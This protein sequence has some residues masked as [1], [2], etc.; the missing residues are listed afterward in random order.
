MW[1]TTGFNILSI[2]FRPIECLQFPRLGFTLIYLI[3]RQCVVF[4][5]LI[6][7]HQC[8]FY[9][10]EHDFRS[11]MLEMRFRRRVGGILLLFIIFHGGGL[12][13]V[14]R[15]V[16]WFSR[17]YWL[18]VYALFYDRS[19]DVSRLV[20]ACDWGWVA[21]ILGLA[22][23]VMSPFFRPLLQIIQE[24]S[25]GIYGRC[26]SLPATIQSFWIF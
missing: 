26:R 5:T 12:F 2:E 4:W 16:I 13:L 14:E 22:C 7:E 17:C 15:F 8:H 1:R 3:H 10:A 18:C 6:S 11:R 25:L 19:R 9:L 21:F 20:F 23:A 24:R